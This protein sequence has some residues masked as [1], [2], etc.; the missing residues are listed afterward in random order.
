MMTARGA[1]GLSRSSGVRWGRAPLLLSGGLTPS[2]GDFCPELLAAHEQRRQPAYLQIDP[3]SKDL[4]P[5]G[6]SCREVDLVA[7]PV[8]PAAV[9]IRE[10]I[11]ARELPRAAEH[12]GAVQ[13]LRILVSAA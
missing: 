12:A 11:V 5:V 6:R 13:H 4:D 9:V 10:S 2:A 7:A 3:G 8:G 1:S